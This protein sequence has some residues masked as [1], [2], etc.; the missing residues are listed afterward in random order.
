MRVRSVTR[1]T[2]LL[3][4][5]EAATRLLIQLKAE[6]RDRIEHGPAA[7]IAECTSP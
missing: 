4:Q 1:K 7:R 2:S 3:N 6:G 5:A